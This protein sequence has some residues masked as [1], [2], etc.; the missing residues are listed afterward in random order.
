MAKLENRRRFPVSDGQ[1][2]TLG[3]A[4]VGDALLHT[5]PI[6]GR[7]CTFAA[8]NAFLVADAWE[9]HPDAGVAFALELDAA[10]EREL[11]PWYEEVRNQDRNAIEVAA[12]LRRGEDP[13]QVHRADGSVDPKGYMRSLVRDGFVPALREDV[14]VLRTFLRIFNLLESPQDLMRNPAVFAKVLEVY[15][16]RESRDEAL[17]GPDRAAVVARL[18]EGPDAPAERLAG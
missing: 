5:N 6:V 1:P 10:V 4:W 17:R 7:G 18:A 15:G 9:A 3:M 16:R 2:V 14:G 8:I 12:R 11:V 13:Y